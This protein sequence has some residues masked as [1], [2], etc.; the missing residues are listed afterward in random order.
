MLRVGLASERPPKVQAAR[1]ALQHLAALGLPAWRDF[2][3]RA[4]A[5]PSGVEATPRHD[6]AL[7]QGARQRAQA[8][9]RRLES[10]ATPAHLY[11]GLEGGVHVDADGRTWLRSWAYAWDG[12][13]GCFGCGPS[14]VLPARLAAPVLAGEDLAAVIDRVAGAED[15]RSRGGTWGWLTHGLVPR[16]LAFETAVLTALVPFYHPEAYEPVG[17]AAP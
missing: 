17:P 14:A 5:T 13:R 16:S 6:G 7:Q 15:V 10:E 11:L 4:H 12:A 9:Q 3:L 8:L 1:A 2:E